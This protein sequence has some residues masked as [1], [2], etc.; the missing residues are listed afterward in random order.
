[1]FSS[2]ATDFSPSSISQEFQLFIFL[3]L[4]CRLIMKNV[5]HEQ[6]KIVKQEGLK[7]LNR[8]PE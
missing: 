2:I 4:E 7:A 6:K 1:M 8:S 5:S 3:L